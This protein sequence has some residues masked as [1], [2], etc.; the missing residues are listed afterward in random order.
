[1]LIQ[2]TFYKIHEYLFL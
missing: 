2:V 1:M